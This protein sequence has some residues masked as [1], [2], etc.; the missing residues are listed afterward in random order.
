M[1]GITLCFLDNLHSHGANAEYVCTSSQFSPPQYHPCLLE[2]RENLPIM[3]SAAVLISGQNLQI[4]I[5]TEGWAVLMSAGN[6]TGDRCV[7]GFP[8]LTPTS[9][10]RSVT[11]GPGRPCRCRNLGGWCVGTDSLRYC[12]LRIATACR[13]AICNRPPK[14]PSRQ[15][16]TLQH[17]TGP[18]GP[19]PTTTYGSKPQPYPRDALTAPAE[20]EW[21]LRTRGRSRLKFAS[22]RSRPDTTLQSGG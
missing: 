14:G 9:A 4:K 13:L 20:L 8:E 17:A 22:G 3:I 6:L 18:D 15:P 10:S 12:N 11:W 7:V 21:G 5:A 2:I 19:F 1:L 16:A